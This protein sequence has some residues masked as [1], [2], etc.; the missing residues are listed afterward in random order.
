MQSNIQT[1]FAG[2]LVLALSII[3]LSVT[4]TNTVHA[5]GDCA[6]PP[7]MGAGFRLTDFCQYQDGVLNEIRGVIPKDGIP[8]IDDPKFDTVAEAREWLVDRSPVIALEIDGEA[9]AYPQSILLWHE[10]VNDEVG[11][12]P[13]AITFCPLC[14]SSIVFD[15]RV[16]DTTLSFGVSGN[17]R[18]SDLIM[19]DR[20][21]ESWWQQFTGEG[22][23]GTYTDTLLDIIPS[24]VV[25]FG[26]F[27][28]R[29]PDGEVLSTATGFGRSYGN[30][31]YAGYDENGSPFLFDDAVD[32]RL[33]AVERVLAGVI[34]GEAM[35][36]PFETLAG[37]PVINDTI[38]ET[39]VVAFWQPGVASAL[40]SGEIATARDIG[41]AALY[42]R[43]LDDQVLTFSL[44]DD[45]LVVDD[46][47]GSVWN[48]FGEAVE[49][50]LTGSS[51]KQ[52]IAAPH[53]W[54]AWAAFRPETLVYGQS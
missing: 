33:F 27:A 11:G 15:R 1:I 35:A 46:Q 10:I 21:T 17:L 18:N 45:G 43:E 53:F 12:I 2:A 34:D 50:E 7:L 44:D 47:T 49:G 28:E 40:G 32:S 9:R 4:P 51:L 25:G 36:Y 42:N 13:V 30:N 54:F 5:Q 29:Y 37:E 3:G 20:E 52:E 24:Q 41:T 31:P 16:D 19:Y 26:T 14:N 23:V 6:K 22:I 39:D 48:V 8:A 38:G